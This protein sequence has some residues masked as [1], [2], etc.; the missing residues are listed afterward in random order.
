MSEQWQLEAHFPEV[1]TAQPELLAHHCAEGGLVERAVEYWFAA[2]E[3]AL[4]ASANVE[5][6]QH[7][8]QSASNRQKSLG[9]Y[10][11]NNDPALAHLADDPL[12]AATEHFG[13]KVANIVLS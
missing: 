10:N 12:R 8:S 5:A 13:A 11:R 1:A 6:I 3:R 4:R 2:G 9:T 7:L